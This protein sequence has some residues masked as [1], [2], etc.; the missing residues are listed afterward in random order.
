MV[1]LKAPS[2]SHPP[3]A[4]TSTAELPGVWTLERGHQQPAGPTRIPNRRQA[5]PTVSVDGGENS[6]IS[7]KV[8]PQALLQTH[9]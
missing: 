9:L 8:V 7:D 4:G 1:G 6:H 3:V 2:L 5:K